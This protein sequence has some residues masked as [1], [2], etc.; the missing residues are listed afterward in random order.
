[1]GV[2]FLSAIP[3]VFRYIV[4]AEFQESYNYIPILVY[5]NIWRVIVG[6]TMGIYIAFKKS[7]EVFLTTLI[8]AIINIATNILLINYIGIYAACVS[9][10]VAYLVMAIYRV[11]ECKRIVNLI[12]DKSR[13][14]IINIIFALVTIAY[15]I[16]VG[17]LNIVVSC[18]VGTFFLAFNRK[19][20]I[21]VIEVVKKRN[22]G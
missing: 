20:L 17:W 9:T 10:L 19:Y 6:L 2:L 22:A 13:F 18:I 15:Y 7:K 12:F 21:N 16:N 8:S 11:K 14:F 1:M 5:A 4:G 3:I